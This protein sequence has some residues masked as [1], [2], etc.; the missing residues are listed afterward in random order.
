MYAAATARITDGSM[1]ATFIF[2][3]QTRFTPMQ[4]ISTEPM[5]DRYSTAAE[6]ITGETSFAS[7]VIAPSKMKTGI[8]EKNRAFS[9]CG[10][11]H[12]DDYKI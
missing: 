2:L 4:K 8:A 9:H 12:C 10:S 11:H 1:F 3:P 7:S 5:S 6:V